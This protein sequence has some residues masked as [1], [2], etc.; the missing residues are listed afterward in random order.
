MTPNI[1]THNHHWQTEKF[2]WP[3]AIM[4]PIGRFKN[5]FFHRDKSWGKWRSLLPCSMC[6]T[7]IIEFSITPYNVVTIIK[8]SPIIQLPWCLHLVAIKIGWFDCI[9]KVRISWS[10]TWERKLAIKPSLIKSPILWCYKRQRQKQ[11]QKIF[12]S[13]DT[14]PCVAMESPTNASSAAWTFPFN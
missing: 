7:I 13:P 14:S 6:N 12:S 10:Y 2:E 11:L 3:T 5:I 1:P 4:L 9:I 8:F